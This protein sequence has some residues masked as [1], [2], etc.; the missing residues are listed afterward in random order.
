MILSSTSASPNE[1]S[2][3]F[4]DVALG[5]WYHND[6]FMFN[7]IN[8]LKY[9]FSGATDIFLNK[10]VHCVAYFPPNWSSSTYT[11]AKIW[12]NGSNKTL[13]LLGGSAVTR[14][15]SSSQNMSIGGGYV[16]GTDDRFNWN[17]NIAL[18]KI[19]N[20]E[21]TDAEVLTKYNAVKDFYLDMP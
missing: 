11:N 5:L 12:I 18:T 3:L 7:N 17:G 6:Q 8:S 2:F 16:S 15:L 20:K 13:S 19:Y 14:T 4:Y 9:G 10:W 1:Y 21:L